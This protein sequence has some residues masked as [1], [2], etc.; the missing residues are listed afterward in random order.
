MI[1]F[2]KVENVTNKQIAPLGIKIF[3]NNKIRLSEEVRTKLG[4]DDDKTIIIL[5]TGSKSFIIAATSIEGVGRS[6]NKAGEFTH[7][8]LAS[9]L[10]GK[11][12]EWV[13][14]GEGTPHPDTGDIYFELKQTVDGAEIEAKLAAIA[15]PEVVEDTESDGP[16][17]TG[18]DA[19]EFNSTEPSDEPADEEPLA[20]V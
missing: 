9:L 3:A 6:I 16:V 13:I 4:M 15:K 12:S 10:G 17:Q 19:F 1:D 7:Q 2:S 18:P 5:K 14:E 11:G 20:V 8:N